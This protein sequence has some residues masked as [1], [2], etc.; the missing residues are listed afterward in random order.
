MVTKDRDAEVGEVAVAAGNVLEGLDRGVEALGGSV[1]DRMPEP[2][3]DALEVRED[4]F[5]DP[6]QRRQSAGVDAP[7]PGIEEREGRGRTLVLPQGAQLLLQGPSQARLEF[8][9]Q[10]QRPQLP[11]TGTVESLPFVEPELSA[12]LEGLIAG[13]L[14]LPMLRPAESIHG[15][16]R[17]ADDV[18]GIVD[19]ARLWQLGRNGCDECRPHIDAHR[20]HRGALLRLETGRQRALGRG[21]GASPPTTSSTRRPAE[22]VSTVA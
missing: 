19:D 12:T 1:G 6:L 8:R 21:L 3:E 15:R 9:C 14:P 11:T 2:S 4:H 13:S 18:E 16:V 22:S 20:L 7:A 17:V 10:E 5:G